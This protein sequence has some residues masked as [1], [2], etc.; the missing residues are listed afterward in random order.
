MERNRYM[1]TLSNVLAPEHVRLNLAAATSEA[2][3]KE[4][5]GLLRDDPDVLDWEKFYSELRVAAPCAAERGCDFGICIP[6]TRTSAVRAMVISVGR[7]EPGLVFEGCP[8]L[9]RYVFC[10]GMPSALDAD[11]LRILGLL[12]RILK[13][14]DT[15]QELRDAQTPSAFVSTLSRLESKL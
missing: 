15:E 2:A 5:A 14:P 6:H 7:F 1:T 11:Y 12:A 8:Q 3:I 13:D 10:I 4:V 9:I